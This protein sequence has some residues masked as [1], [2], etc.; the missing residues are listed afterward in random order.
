[1]KVRNGFVTN[2]SSSSYVI[3]YRKMPELDDETL[4]KYPWL[5]GYG[6]LLERALLVEGNYSDTTE[7]RV[8]RTKEELDY[9]FID[10]YGWGNDKSV[11]DVIAHDDEGMYERYEEMCKYVE[12]GFNIL[13]K[14]IDNNDDVY[15]IILAEMAKDNENLVIL[16]DE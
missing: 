14:N 8:A 12:G 5:K 16:E 7:G 15:M 13:F 2:S 11:K 10:E 6:K 9:L 4:H 3:A 1:M